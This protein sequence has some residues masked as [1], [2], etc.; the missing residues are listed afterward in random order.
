LSNPGIGHELSRFEPGFIKRAA[1]GVEHDIEERLLNRESFPADKGSHYFWSSACQY[2]EH[3]SIKRI[4]PHTGEV[5]ITYKNGILVIL[6]PPKDGKPI[7][8]TSATHNFDGFLSTSLQTLLFP[9][10]ET[11]RLYERDNPRSSHDEINMRTFQTRDSLRIGVILVVALIINEPHVAITKLGKS[12]ILPHIENVAFADMGKA[13]QQ[14]TL[15]EVLQFYQTKP[16]MSDAE[17]SE[18]K[19]HVNIQDQVKAKLAM[20]LQE[21]G[22]ELVR[23][24][25]ETVKV[26]DA[27][28]AKQL[29]GQSITS[30][31]Y[32]TKQATLVK[33]YD[34]KTT[35]AK[36][37]AETE[38]IAI[39]QL[40]QSVISQARA[41]LEASKLEA[42]ALIIA[43]EARQKVEAMRGTILRDYP[44]MFELEMMK[45]KIDILQKTT[46]YATPQDIGGFLSSP[47]GMFAA[48][49]LMKDGKHQQ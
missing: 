8:I 21:Y 40:N 44:Q 22:I 39:M 24:N 34:I 48:L 37:R 35:E 13:I 17:K 25:I 9:S 49:S 16:N 33:E 29:A 32:T 11:K 1:G 5:A 31:E 41:K 2:I 28:I 43:A 47:V 38:N 6:D 42:E 10:D 23:L 45:L 7:M 4:I 14:S 3:G 36:M 12:G 30:A 19:P 46:I 26:L 27:D 18:D 20:D 15:Q